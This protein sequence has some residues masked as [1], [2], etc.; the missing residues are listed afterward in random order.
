[1]ESVNVVIDT[2]VLAAALRSKLGDS[3]K[4]LILLP[5]DEY[6][7]N[8]SVPLFVEYESLIKRGNA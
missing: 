5:N 7:P 2:S 4:L 1:M 6:Q 8:I 3:H